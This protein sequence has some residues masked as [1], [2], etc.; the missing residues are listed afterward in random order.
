[1]SEVRDLWG[2]DQYD[3][4]SP[5]LRP[6]ELDRIHSAYQ[7]WLDLTMETEKYDDAA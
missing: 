4:D 7:L 5:Y 1:V 6:V 2:I 3:E